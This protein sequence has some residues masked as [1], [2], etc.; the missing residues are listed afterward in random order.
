MGK[1]VE[2]ERAPEHRRGG[3]H[4]T[5]G[6]GEQAESTID[7]LS[8]PRRDRDPWVPRVPRDIEPSLLR[9]EAHDLS[10][11][12]RVPLGLLVNDGREAR[13]AGGFDRCVDECRNLRFAQARESEMPGR[14][15]AVHLE[16][17]PSEVFGQ[18][19]RRRGTRRGRGHERRRAGPPGT[20]E[21]AATEHRPRAGRRGRARGVRPL[22]CPA[23]TWLS[24]RTTGSERSRDR[25]RVAPAGRGSGPGAP[26][27][28]G[29][30]RRHSSR[31]RRGAPGGRR[32]GNIRAAP[33]SRANRRAR[34]R[35]P[36]TVPTRREPRGAGHELRVRSRAGSCRSPAHRR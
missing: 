27:G 20:R 23:G 5:A 19:I 29:R 33:G 24:N 36:N 18:E 12:E 3:K 22:R 14:W 31:A 34:R 9:E 8:D 11:E 16:D 35:L 7:H 28:S 21:A 17:D 13:R 4:L 6:L 26:G 2:A 25:G 15:L 32:P 10:D 1:G 30:C